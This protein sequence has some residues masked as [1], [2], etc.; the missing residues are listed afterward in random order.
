VKN[1]AAAA[2]ALYVAETLVQGLQEKVS[3]LEEETTR[4]KVAMAQRERL[5][6]QAIAVASTAAKARVRTVVTTRPGARITYPA[7]PL[8][9]SKVSAS[10]RCPSSYRF[11]CSIQ[12]V[13]I[14]S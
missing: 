3:A 2:A 11:G 10:I 6:R 8:L 7:M 5:E 9:P 1:C 12:L 13:T 4:L 14:A